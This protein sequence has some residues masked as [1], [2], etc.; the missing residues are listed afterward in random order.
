[1]KH[2]QGVC[3]C[4]SLRAELY[5]VAKQNKPKIECAVHVYIPGFVDGQLIE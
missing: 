4:A 2:A 1:M 5:R 3:G